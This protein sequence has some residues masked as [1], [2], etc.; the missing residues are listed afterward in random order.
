MITARRVERADGGP[1]AGGRIIQLGA[2]QIPAAAVAPRDQNLA[3]GQQRRCV[4]LARGAERGGVDPI[5]I[6]LRR[7]SQGQAH[8][9]CHQSQCDWKEVVSFHRVWVLLRSEWSGLPKPNEADS[10]TQPLAARGDQASCDRPSSLL[11]H[12]RTVIRSPE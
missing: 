1:D 2:G 3:I 12:G 8:C 11:C 5:R 6:R 7:L 4:K 9:Q 10:A